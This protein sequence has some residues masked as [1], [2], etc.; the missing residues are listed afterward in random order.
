M[1]FVIHPSKSVLTL[2][3]TVVFLRSVILSNHMMLSLTDEKKNKIKTLF[4]NCLHSHQ[5][6]IREL[7]RTLGNFVA[8]FLAATFGTLDDRHFE[9]DKIRG[10]K[11]HKG[12]FEEKN[13]LSS[14]AESEILVD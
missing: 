3:Q 13:N 6:S 9:K 14:K 12:N 4:I 7:A 10:L 1:G 11:Y 8:S 5:L 2:S